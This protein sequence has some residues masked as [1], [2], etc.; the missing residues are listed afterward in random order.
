MVAPAILPSSGH[1]IILA[2]SSV[3]GLVIGPSLL[4]SIDPTIGPAISL[5]IGTT[6]VPAGFPDVTPILSQEQYR[7]CVEMSF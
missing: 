7:W 2:T 5:A 3:F 1:A 6:V 4:L